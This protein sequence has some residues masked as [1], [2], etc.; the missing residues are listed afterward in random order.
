[1][2][3]RD[4]NDFVPKPIELKLICAK[5]KKWLSKEKIQKCNVIP[6]QEIP[7]KKETQ[8]SIEK[9]DVQYALKLL[10]SEELFFDVL[11]DYY[12]TIQAKSAQ[13]QKLEKDE[14]WKNYTIEV[15]ALK[16]SSRQIGATELSDLAKEMED[17]GNHKNVDKIHRLT[18]KMLEK[19]MEYEK[20][21]AP[22]FAKSQSTNIQKPKMYPDLLSDCFST[23]H[24]ALENLDICLLYTSQLHQVL[25]QAHQLHQQH[26]V[27]HQSQV[28]HRNQVRHQNQVQLQN[29]L[30]HRTRIHQ[31]EWDGR[32]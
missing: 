29:R 12:Q 22:Y 27:L 24:I 6:L 18:G 25:H 30:Q 23:L 10:G 32:R 20:I 2:C 4:R 31:K 3:I 7:L 5:L 28:K 17:A 8:C 9:L 1:M 13:I 15:H 26:L 19:Y 16:S 14:D 11:K 21:L